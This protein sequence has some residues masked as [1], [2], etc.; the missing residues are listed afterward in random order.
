MKFYLF[1]FII[2]IHVTDSHNDNYFLL[3]YENQNLPQNLENSQQ[4]M[5][6]ICFGYSFF[7]GNIL[8]S[9]NASIP[10]KLALHKNGIFTIIA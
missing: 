1:I 5:R 10:I 8:L 6:L 9:W 7:S 4:P 3:I 2:G